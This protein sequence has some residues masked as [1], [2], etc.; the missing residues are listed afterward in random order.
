MD[1][2]LTSAEMMSSILNIFFGNG[3]RNLDRIPTKQQKN[4]TKKAIEQSSF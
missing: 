2:T 4:P 3:E 1:S